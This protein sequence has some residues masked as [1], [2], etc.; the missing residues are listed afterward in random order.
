MCR[1]L[2]AKIFVDTFAN[3]EVTKLIPRMCHYGRY[4]HS[5]DNIGVRNRRKK[6]QGSCSAMSRMK[7]VPGA[8][9]GEMCPMP[10]SCHCYGSGLFGYLFLLL[11]EIWSSLSLLLN[12]N[13]K[14]S[15]RKP[16]NLAIYIYNSCRIYSAPL[17]PH[18]STILRGWCLAEV[19]GW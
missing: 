6:Y 5:S 18:P 14:M 11:T 9:S 1:L 2:F 3:L 7:G 19:C 15:N 16:R 10:P 13:A 4:R 12:F 17:V 8:S